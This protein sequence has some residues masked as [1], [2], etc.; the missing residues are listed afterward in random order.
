MV[1]TTEP[2][3]MIELNDSNKRQLEH[4]LEAG[5]LGIPFSLRAGRLV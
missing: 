1:T 2:M 5:E 3:L 4:D